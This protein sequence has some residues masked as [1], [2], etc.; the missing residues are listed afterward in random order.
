MRRAS[1]L[2]TVSFCLSGCGEVHFADPNVRYVAIGDSSTRGPS[3]RDYLDILRDL[4]NEP[5]EAFANEG[6]GGSTSNEGL[7]KIGQLIQQGFYPNAHTLLYWQGGGDIVDFMIDVDPL[8]L[9]APD[10]DLYPFASRLDEV[11]DEI[12]ANIE[13]L[14]ETAKDAGWSVYVATYYFGREA[15]GPCENL[16]LD[17]ILPSQARN[18]NV[19][20]GL[21]NER[22]R[23]AAAN[24]GA[25]L[26]DVSSLNDVLRSDKA[27]Y[28]DCNHLSAQGNGLVAELF[29]DVLVSEAN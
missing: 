2:L 14:I 5:A 21:L 18:A 29:R 12:Q 8:L 15:L 7:E 27:N 20:I 22:I 16:F 11:L 1:I 13:A 9:L 6:K 4:L 28:F 26:V 25:V 3:A 19:Y 10:S 23:L 17:T 24:T